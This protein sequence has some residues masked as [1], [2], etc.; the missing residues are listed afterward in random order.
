MTP[1]IKPLVCHGLLRPWV[2]LVRSYEQQENKSCPTC[3]KAPLLTTCFHAGQKS[4]T[5]EEASAARS[6]HA[7]RR[8]SA[9]QHPAATRHPPAP[10][11][12]WHC[13]SVMLLSYGSF[14]PWDVLRAMLKARGRDHFLKNLGSVERFLPKPSSTHAARAPA[15]CS[16]AG[17]E[18]TGNKSAL[19]EVSLPCY[20]DAVTKP[21][22]SKSAA[23]RSILPVH[24]TPTCTCQADTGLPCPW[25]QKVHTPSP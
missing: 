14:R 3:K 6:A 5:S 24:V 18:S 15:S 8:G 12:R 20:V 1:T 16:S 17:P 4:S 13:G 22:L 19:Q 23:A 9:W 25:F 7:H 10:A 21:S 2:L 11:A